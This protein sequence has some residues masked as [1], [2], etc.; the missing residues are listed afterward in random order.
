[1]YTIGI[2]ED[3]KDLRDSFDEYAKLNNLFFII[4]SCGSI[5]EWIRVKHVSEI[6]PDFILLDI[7]LPGISGIKGLAQLKSFY[8]N[9]NII[10]IS[11]ESD[12]LTIWD[13]LIDGA[14]GFITKP[15]NFS[16][17]LNKMTVVK[18]G[19]VSVDAVSLRKIIEIGGANKKRAAHNRSSKSKITKREQQVVDFLLEGYS[20]LEVATFLS[21][22][23]ATVNQ[24]IK[25]IYK[26]FKVK[27][28]T[29]LSA[30]LLN[31]P[32]KEKTHV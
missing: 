14:D 29:Q 20:Y 5:E 12:P 3:D 8:K 15:F 17:I 10:F 16:D 31:N 21:I 32:T 22:S 9:S 2:I 4:F 18:N 26:K 27:S 1:M 25:N 11:G 28:K 6:I 19:G 30:K 23:Y 24:H 7:G 13:A